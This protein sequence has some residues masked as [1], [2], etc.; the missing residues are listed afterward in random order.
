MLEACSAKTNS[1]Q[2]IRSNMKINRSHI[3]FGIL[4]TYLLIFS[5]FMTIGVLKENQVS[6]AWFE[7]RRPGEL[8]ESQGGTIQLTN[9]LDRVFIHNNDAIGRREGVYPD[10]GQGHTGFDIPGRYEVYYF[11]RDIGD[12]TG[13]GE[14]SREK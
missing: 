1:V 11:V 10:I 6:S 13:N 9:D 14:I 2:S 12:G 4:L 7:V 5:V 3:F 8:P